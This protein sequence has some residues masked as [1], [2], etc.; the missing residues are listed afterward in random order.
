M[1]RTQCGGCGSGGA[2]STVLDLGRSPLADD[3][4]DTREAAIALERWPLELLHCDACSLVQLGELV[5]DAILWG[6]DYGFY[7]SASSVVVEHS[8]RYAE[9]LMQR[10]GR[11][12]RQLTVEIA[13]NDG[14]LLKPLQDR[15]AFVL[16]IDPAAGP[17][18]GAL[19]R[20]V[21][22]WQE[23]FTRAAARKIVDQQGQAG[24]VVANNVIAHV[25]DL[26]DFAAGLG[27]LL[28]NDGVAVV[29]FQ[30][31][32]DLLLGNMFDHVYHEHRQFFSLTSLTRALAPHGLHPID[33]E[34]HD[35]QG[36]SLRVTLAKLGHPSHAVRH[37]M[38]AESQLDAVGALGGLQVRAERIAARLRD[39]LYQAQREGLKVA[40]YGASA[41]STTLL[42]FCRIDAELVPYFLD[43]TPTKVGRFTPGTGIPIV[44]PTM[45][46][47]RPDIHLL[48]VWNYLPQIMARE[49]QFSDRGGRWLVPIPA[50]VLL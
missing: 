5:D 36:G 7:S 30:Y 10:F 25:A 45:D 43:T 15:G 23:R 22:T 49:R 14:V 47:R 18:A 33:V 28:H 26:Q 29:E 20:G 35:M 6:G 12:A 24:L 13:S 17:G 31:L 8:E 9:W 48:T 37:L 39:M 32:P 3:F 41:K 38:Q 44:S 46:S 11:L 16:G 21:E 4:R 1:K 42:N 40:G 50:P 2:L 27:V 19:A 34:Q